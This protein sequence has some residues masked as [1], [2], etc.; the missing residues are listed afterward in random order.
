M[1]RTWGA[2]VLGAAQDT[3]RSIV[4]AAQNVQGWS[5]AITTLLALLATANLLGNVP[6]GYTLTTS[7]VVASVLSLSFWL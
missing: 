3:S 5:G 6:G 7:V 4:G 2:V 1:Q